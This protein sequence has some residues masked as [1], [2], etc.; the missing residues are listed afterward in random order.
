MDHGNRRSAGLRHDERERDH[1]DDEQHEREQSGGLAL[2]T[3]DDPEFLHFM[4]S[5]R[6][7]AV[8]PCR[9]VAQAV[10]GCPATLV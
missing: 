6:H 4:R 10:M 5:L 8:V 1:N 7:C 9:A 3:V 2:E